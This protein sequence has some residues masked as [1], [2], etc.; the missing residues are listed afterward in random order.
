MTSNASITPSPSS[1]DTY[2]Y[3]FN[4]SDTRD[5]RNGGG[6]PNTPGTGA[7]SG[8]PTPSANVTSG[9]PTPTA[10][11]T[12]GFPTPSDNGTSS[13][14]PT[15]S[16]NLTSSGFPT[17]SGNDTTYGTSGFPSPTINGTSSGFPTSSANASTCFFTVR[18]DFD[19]SECLL[20]D[21]NQN[22]LTETTTL[23]VCESYVYTVYTTAPKSSIGSTKTITQTLTI[24]VKH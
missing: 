23:S 1:T 18:I 24:A 12:S 2:D 17:P 6:R 4:V 9:F 22:Y 7:S 19:L 13:G 14:F 16:A 10:N 15:P 8:F 20:M 21:T 5:P 11:G 3:S